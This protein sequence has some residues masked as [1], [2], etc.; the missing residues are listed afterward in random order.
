VCD[1][2]LAELAKLFHYAKRA[3]DEIP[4]GSFLVNM[5]LAPI[6]SRNVSGDRQLFFK[7]SIKFREPREDIGYCFSVPEMRDK[8]L[9]LMMSTSM[10]CVKSLV[11]SFLNRIYLQMTFQSSMSLTADFI[12]SYLI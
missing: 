8:Y 10:L 5:T 12:L 11:L 1:E 3:V 9:L 4:A 7:F 2:R 6:F